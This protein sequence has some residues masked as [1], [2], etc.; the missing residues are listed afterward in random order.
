MDDEDDR[1]TPQ[2][3]EEIRKSKLAIMGIKEN[4]ERLQEREGKDI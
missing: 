2:K 1:T 3:M 4:K